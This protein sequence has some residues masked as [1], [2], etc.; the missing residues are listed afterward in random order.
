MKRFPQKVYIKWEEDEGDSF[1]LVG[2]KPEKISNNES[3]TP[4]GEYVLNRKVVLVNKT[5]VIG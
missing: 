5:E 2:E 4:A 3:E 1:L